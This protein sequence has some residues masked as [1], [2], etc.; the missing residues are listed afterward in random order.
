MHEVPEGLNHVIIQAMEMKM[1]DIIMPCFNSDQ[2]IY[3]SKRSLLIGLSYGV[4]CNLSPDEK[5]KN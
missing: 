4:S 1:L 2:V 5:R 3:N